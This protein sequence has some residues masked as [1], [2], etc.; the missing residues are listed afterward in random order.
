M[1]QLSKSEI[2]TIKKALV[3][4]LGTTESNDK[5]RQ[6]ALQIVWAA[7]RNQ[8]LTIDEIFAE[9]E[10]S[11]DELYAELAPHY[12]GESE[13]SWHGLAMPWKENT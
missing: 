13:K 5:Y 6:D 2:E 4:S 3:L 10:I 8:N 11:I 9:S 7:L 12:K 1:Y